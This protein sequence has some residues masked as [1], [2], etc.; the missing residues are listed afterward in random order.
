MTMEL[1]SKSQIKR[2]QCLAPEAVEEEIM[3]LRATVQDQELQIKQLRCE[4]NAAREEVRKTKA[5]LGEISDICEDVV[6]ERL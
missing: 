5:K 1:K 6:G 3:R 4:L 2:V